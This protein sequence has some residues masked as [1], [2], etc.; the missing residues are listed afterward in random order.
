MAGLLEMIE[1]CSRTDLLVEQD[2]AAVHAKAQA[3]A[4]AAAL[5]PLL[6]AQKNPRQRLG[7][8]FLCGQR[9][10]FRDRCRNIS[11]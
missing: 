4:F 9:G 11:K 2:K 10:H 6:Q 1:A 7:V 8:C 5:K 3:S